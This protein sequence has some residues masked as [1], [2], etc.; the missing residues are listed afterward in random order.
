MS[1][2]ADFRTV[3]GQFPWSR[4][5]SDGQHIHIPDKW[6]FTDTVDLRLQ[7]HS[8]STSIKP[9]SHFSAVIY[10][11]ATGVFQVVQKSMTWAS[12]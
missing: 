4:I 12:P 7:A 1:R 10:P 9:V 3:F 6:S 2:H 11:L 5:E 8:L